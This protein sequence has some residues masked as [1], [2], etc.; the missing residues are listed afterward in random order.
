M[1][2]VFVVALLAMNP[3]DYLFGTRRERLRLVTSQ[4]PPYPSRSP[5]AHPSGWTRTQGLSRMD[6]HAHPLRDAP[7]QDVELAAGEIASVLQAASILL[8]STSVSALSGRTPQ[9]ERRWTYAPHSIDRQE[10][11]QCA[12]PPPR[13]A[14][15]Y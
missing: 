5:R 13:R 9:Y 11:L 8:A 6:S 10:Q 4:G 2:F 14:Y 3:R 15:S 12:T 1:L 7:H